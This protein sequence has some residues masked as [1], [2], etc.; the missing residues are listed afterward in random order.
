MDNETFDASKLIKNQPWIDRALENIAPTW[1]L[2]RLEARVQKS[3]FEYNAARTNRLYAPKQYGQPAEST[4]NQRD[5]VVMM[6]EARDLVE[7]SPEAR[8][9]SRKFGLYLTPHE[10]SPTTGDRDYN[11]TVSDY[12]HEWCK[13]CDVT[14]RHSF[15]KLVQLAA[16]ERPVDGDCGF[17]IRR[18]GDG[19]KLQ[20]VPATRIGNPNSAA[21][22]SNNYFQGIITDDFGQ[23]IAYRIYRVDRNGV[24]FGAEDIPANQFAHYFDP[25]RVDQYRGITDFHSAIQT[26][27]MLHDI[28]QAEKAGVRFSSQQAALIFNDR[29]VANPR[30]LFQPNPALSLP[31]GQQQKNELTEVGMIRYFQN[32]DRVEVMPSRPSQAFTG[33]VQHLMHEIALGIGVPEGVL[34]GTQDYKGPSVRAEFAAADRVFTRQQGVLTDKVLDPIK[35]AVILDAIARGEIPPPTLLAGETMVQALRRATKGEWRF[36]AKLSIDVGRESAAN[37]NENRQGAK[38]LQEIAAEEGTDAFSRLEQIAIEAGFVKELAT[39]YGVPETAIRL[40]TNQLPSTPAAAA[41]A[42]DAVGTSAAEAQK[43]SATASTSGAITDAAI[44]AGVE[45]FPDVSADLVPLNGA[46]ISAVLSILEN[47]RAGDL[48]AEAAETLMI[49]AGMAQESAKK[50]SGSVA[51]LPKQPTKISAESMHK[52]IQLA[53]LSSSATEDSNLVTIDFATNTYIPTVAIANNAKRALEIREKKPASQRGM[54]SVGIARARDLMNRRPLSED[55]VRRMKAYFDRHEADKQG[56]TWDEQG[57]GWQAWN[58]WGGDEG[59]SWATA[60]V[61]R[62]NK[63][64]DSKELKAASSEVRQS[65]AALQPPEPEEWLDAVQNYRKKQNGRVDEIKLSIIGEK[66]IV[67]LSKVSKKEFIIPTPDVGEKSDAFMGRCMSNPTMLAEYPDESQRA[68]VCNAQIGLEKKAMTEGDQ[69]PVETQDIKAN[70]ANRQKAVNIANYGPANPQLPNADY[71][72]AK[73]AQFKTSINEAK[74]MRCGNCAAFNVS[75]R[76][77][78]CINKGIGADASEVEKAGELGYCEFFDF[79]CAAKRTCDAWVVGGPIKS[80]SK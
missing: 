38:S 39:K 59:Y 51:N 12:F 31:S 3:L 37:M 7:N 33:F 21:V 2:K 16:E 76:I 61:E 30:N 69:C 77:K 70:L 44:I 46:Q 1:A 79:K 14:G 48:T 5:R 29:G 63:Q 36:P 4:Q 58:G 65:F 20:L 78:D 41:A 74:T 68:A 72:T 40:T 10:Y 26:V 53:R 64:A 60:I 8:E 22:E 34:F 25:F 6:W 67:E 50:V 35:D 52:R 54:T 56:D 9:V 19:L 57:K 13:H 11:Q 18:A 71:W 49:S 32:S 24:Y 75:P 45:S 28:L 66:S 43:A 15:K 80:E 73:A 47:L 17:V 42:G 62:L 55:T 27:R 23:P